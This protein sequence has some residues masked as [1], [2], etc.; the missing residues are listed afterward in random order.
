MKMGQPYSSDIWDACELWSRDQIAA[1]QLSSLKTQLQYV[2]ENSAYYRDAFGA[3]GFDPRGL[4]SLDDLRKLPVTRKKDY[5][6]AI[7]SAPPP[8]ASKTR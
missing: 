3:A 7:P 1:H 5:V 2:G 8:R 6:S 4:T